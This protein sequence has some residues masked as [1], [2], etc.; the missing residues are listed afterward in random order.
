MKAII[1]GKLYCT[2][3]A[4][5]IL[6]FTRRV[7]KGPV[8]WNPEFHWMMTHT[9]VLYKTKKAAYFEHD[10]DAG[11]I[12]ALSCSDVERIVRRASPE[13][14]IELFGPVEDA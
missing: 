4:E 6:R 5:E 14:Y 7:D 8:L 1:D 13:K 9:F 2:D 3:A 11:T 10:E 12:A